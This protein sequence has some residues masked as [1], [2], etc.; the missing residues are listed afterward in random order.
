VIAHRTAMM[1]R[2]ARPVRQGGVHGC[3]ADLLHAGRDRSSR[4]VTAGHRKTSPEFS[5]WTARAR[6]GELRIIR[7][8][9]SLCGPVPSRSQR[10]RGWRSC[11]ERGALSTRPL[12]G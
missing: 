6:A 7:P 11:R 10:S 5:R 8:R 3:N 12:A 2:R 1:P 9:A 4:S